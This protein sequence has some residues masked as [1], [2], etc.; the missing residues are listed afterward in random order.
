[1]GIVIAGGASFCNSSLFVATDCVESMTMQQGGLGLIMSMLI[2]GAPPMAAMPFRGT[3]GQFS[4]YSVFPGSQQQS[5]AL[6]GS[7]GNPGYPGYQAYA[8][9]TPQVTSVTPNYRPQA[10]SPDLK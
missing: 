7:R 1:M 2:V 4:G 6:P 8:P 3:L 10:V 9:P 5:S